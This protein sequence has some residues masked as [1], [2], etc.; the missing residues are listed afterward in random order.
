MHSSK[1]ITK[2]ADIPALKSG[3]L[4]CLETGRVSDALRDGRIELFYQPI[5]RTGCDSLVAFYEGLVRIRMPD[6]TIVAAGRFMP[7]V[8]STPLGTEIDRRVLRLALAFLGDHPD[9]RLSINMGVASMTDP[10]WRGILEEADSRL[11]E[12]LI[13]EITEGTAMSDVDITNAFLHGVRQKGCSVALDDFGTGATTFRYFKDFL[14]DFVK[15]DGMFIRDLALDKTNQVLV[16]AL[17]NISKHFDMVTIAEFVETTDEAE[18]AAKLG[19]DCLQGYL[20]GEPT[21]QPMLPYRS[22]PLKRKVVG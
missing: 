12:R 11:C 4:S 14:F 2:N 17:V 10:V 8:D 5:I 9:T 1:Q 16:E 19:V 15:I 18:M 3:P 7:F 21:A 22:Q 13:V 20:I 6:G